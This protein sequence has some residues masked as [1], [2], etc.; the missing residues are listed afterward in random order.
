M[1]RLVSAIETRETHLSWLVLLED[2]VFKVKKPV[3]T[4]FVD[5]STRE[6]RQRNADDE[7]RLNRRLAPDVYLGVA[8]LAGVPGLDEP[9]VVMRRMPEDRRLA[10]LAARGDDLAEAVRDL[11]RRLAAFHAQVPVVPRAGSSQAVLALWEAGRSQLGVHGRGVLDP[12]VVEQVAALGAR[13]VRG[14]PALFDGRADRVREGH[15][16]LLADDVFLL[17]DGPRV[18]DCLE[19]DLAL[20]AGDVLSD[21]AFLAMDLEHLG[22]VDLAQELL[23]VHRDETGDDW[24]ASLADHWVAYRAWVRA[25]VACLRVE[26]GGAEQAAQARDLLELARRRVR[27]ATVRLVLVGGA[28][29]T[30][31]STLAAEL[32]ART[33]FALLRSDVVR[34]ELA[35]V[36]PTTSVSAGPGEG[37]YAPEVT[38]RLL[39]ELLRRARELLAHGR[40]VLLDASWAGPAWRSAAEALASQCQVDL[41][42]LRTVVPDE[43]ADAR[44][45]ARTGDASDATPEVA[46]WLRERFAPWP[47]AREVRTDRPASQL[48]AELAPELLT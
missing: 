26:Q 46:A 39:E 20:R 47:Q 32:A 8:T 43:V 44:L 11:A 4:E 12:D 15:G 6:A 23:R 30:G 22:R 48:A 3:R 10:L 40:S 16:D 36:P 35:G 14:R 31:K 21:V 33:G 9:V 19:F 28:P 37:L 5:L 38:Q 41:V 17:D 7:V 1:A 34:K 25:K 27:R 18:L 2:R 42:Q 24:P 45:V 13:Y 29:G